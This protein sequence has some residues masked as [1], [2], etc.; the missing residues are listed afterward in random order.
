MAAALAH[1]AVN[2]NKKDVAL[3]ESLGAVR[4]AAQAQTEMVQ[5]ESRNTADTQNFE[6]VVREA[7]ANF[8]GKSDEETIGIIS[9]YAEKLIDSGFAGQQLTKDLITNNR[10]QLQFLANIADNQDLLDAIQSAADQISQADTNSNAYKTEVGRIAA[11]KAGY[12][13]SGMTGSALENFYLNLYNDLESKV[14]EK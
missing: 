9:D 5:L 3:I 1:V 7:T 6:Q 4:E 8:V 14:N 2:E 13:T 10:N 11:E 12:D